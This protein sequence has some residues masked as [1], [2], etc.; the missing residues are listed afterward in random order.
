M[1]I[2]TTKQSKGPKNMCNIH[3]ALSGVKWITR[4]IA[5]GWEGLISTVW[6]C[7]VCAITTWPYLGLVFWWTM[8]MEQSLWASSDRQ[9]ECSMQ[10]V[11]SAYF[12]LCITYQHTCCNKMFCSSS[13]AAS[14]LSHYCC[15]SARVLIFKYD[16]SF[17]HSV[18]TQSLA[19]LHL[20]ILKLKIDSTRC[21]YY[22]EW[23]GR[24]IWVWNKV[25]SIHCMNHS[26]NDGFQ[27]K[28][29]ELVNSYLHLYNVTILYSHT[30]THRLDKI[31]K[32]YEITL[33]EIGCLTFL[34]LY[35]FRII[36]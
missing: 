14:V 16:G 27:E 26:N 11:H 5:Y 18:F 19:H 30:V 1:F 23:W 13:L 17:T 33:S 35:N 24:Y 2:M 4:H 36:S 25:S 20:W 12:I 7:C 3:A 15:C 22:H 8:K 28:V 32:D 31:A 9:L 21:N 6:V 29:T 34:Q 10:R